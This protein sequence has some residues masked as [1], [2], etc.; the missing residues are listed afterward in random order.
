MA[1]SFVYFF[2]QVF[3]VSTIILTTMD[4]PEMKH[5]SM[6]TMP[7]GFRDLL[8]GCLKCNRISAWEYSEFSAYSSG[9]LRIDSETFLFRSL[10]RKLA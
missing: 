10:F 2:I 1:G 5:I 8:P 6:Q 9:S 3:I 7:K 4:C